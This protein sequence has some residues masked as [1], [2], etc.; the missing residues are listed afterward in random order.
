MNCKPSNKCVAETNWS[1]LQGAAPF[2][3]RT[4]RTS[5][6]SWHPALQVD[7]AALDRAL[8]CEML[9]LVEGDSGPDAPPARRPLPERHAPG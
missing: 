3:A 5:R 7:A 4:Q 1:L 6:C 2:A 8:A 9:R